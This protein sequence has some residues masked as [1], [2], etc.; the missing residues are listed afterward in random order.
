MD[1]L[2]LID[3]N[4]LI[5]RAFYAT[6]PM[7]N[8]EGVPTNAVF[9]FTNML[10]RL[11]KEESPTHV[12]V[13]FD[14]KAP[15]FRHKMYD[16]Y[17]ATRKPMPD[18]LAKQ[19]PLLKELLKVMGIEILE[20]AG[21][22]A[23]DI[24]GTV[25][26][27]THIKTIIVTGDRDSFQLVDDETEVHFTRRGISDVDVLTVENFFEKVGFSPLQVIDYKA[28]AGDSSDNIPGINGVGEKTAKT[29]LAT[30][31]TVENLYEHTDE[32]KGKLAEN[33]IACK[34]IAFLSKA[35]ATIDVNA[36]VDFDTEEMR[37]KLP[38]S[39]KVKQEFAKLEFKILLKR[40][41]MFEKTDE[42]RFSEEKGDPGIQTKEIKTTGELGNV[43]FGEFFAVTYSG[44]LSV[45]TDGVNYN[46]TERQTLFDEGVDIVD[47]FKRLKPVLDDENK[48]LIVF[49][50]KDFEYAVRDFGITVKCKTEDV[51]LMKYLADY[52]D[53]KET[54]DDIIVRRGYNPFSPAY[55]LYVYYEELKGIL[56]AQ[57]MKSLYYDVELPLA[58]V[59]YDME[60]TGFKADIPGLK[61]LSEEYLTEAENL[62]E[63]IYELAGEKFNVNSPKQL[64]EILFDKMAI[65]KG[66]KKSGGYSTTAEELE[67]YADK[68]EIVKYILRYRKV[69]KFRSTY[70][71]GLLA[72]ADKNTG[73]IH[74]RFNQ[75][76]TSTGR[77]SSAEPNLQNIPVREEESAKIRRCLI[78]RDD[79]HVLV[80]ADYSQIELRLLAVFSDCEPL[81][82]AFLKGEDIHTLTA[83]KVF[84]VKPEEVTKIQRRRAKAVN[85]GIIYGISEYGLAKDVKTSP[86]EAKRYIDSYFAEYPEVKAYMDKNVAM[87]KENGYVT[88][89]MGRRRVIRELKSAS[90][91]MRQFGERA[92][93]NMPLQGSS[94]DIIKV[95]MINVYNRLKR[96]NLKSKLVL[97]V[98]DE[99]VVDALESE[100]ERVEKLLTEEMENA[101]KLSVPLTVEAE[102]GK[103]LC[104]E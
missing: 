20:K 25:A 6:P 1:K 10:F 26:K 78:A 76:V 11:L 3:G 79:E 90:F 61:R 45:Y 59:L 37:I 40:E 64:G 93:M 4:S 29:L 7:F 16:G 43:P 46:V 89:L 96:E 17:K 30:Y 13:A 60:N 47:F 33:V 34:D 39:Y 15:T 104:M 12:C 58:D 91:Q 18:D 77:L 35:L 81:K 68:N 103:N 73:L 63:K 36:D 28:I 49:G 54:L 48:T 44:K 53:R 88:T 56:E 102:S 21:Y 100:K 51:S 65:G 5:N 38:F 50:K 87:A 23:D 24:I 74:T 98:H 57:E 97:Q 55:A 99:L 19:V 67:K 2:V 70:V 66:K 71:E 52:S 82:E 42:G 14:L 84:G 80:G 94:A 9:G 75:T 101:V 92:A 62:C 27:H 86:A 83:C 32:L 41:D 8:G 72:V 95:A 31:G 85:F 22:E 69:Q